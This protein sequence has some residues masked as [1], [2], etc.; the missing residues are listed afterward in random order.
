M[1]SVDDDAA[2]RNL[3]KGALADEGY[4]V[5]EAA[6]GA[7]VR[8][9]LEVVTPDVVLLD[10]GLPDVDGVELCRRL[11]TSPGVPIIV[12]S[13]DHDEPRIVGA[14][15]AGANDYITKPFS[16]GNLLARLRVAVRQLTQ[17]A[18]PDIDPVVVG[19]LV[20]DPVAHQVVAGGRQ[21]GLRAREYDVLERLMRNAGAMLSFAALSAT[22]GRAVTGRDP[23]AL[24]I[25]IS[26]LRA[27]IGTGPKRPTIATEPRHGYRL[28]E[29]EA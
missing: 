28:V 26:R 23:N 22:D 9:V 21:L 14:L 19:D 2:H 7:D 12:V 4:R 15:D 3:L 17:A 27:A 24:R 10:L 18:V 20:L 29:P 11:A 1:L 8:K 16:L 25:T 6:S 13:A 5:V